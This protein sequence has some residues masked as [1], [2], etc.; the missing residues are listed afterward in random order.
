MLVVIVVYIGSVMSRHVAFQFRTPSSLLIVGPSG[1][2]KTVFTVRLLTD[3]LDLFATRP[4]RMHYCY[5]SWQKTFETLKR[6]GVTFSAGVLSE[7]DLD[8]WFPQGGLLVMD[9][10]M[11][12]GNNDKTV[13]DIFTKHSHHRNITVLY[14]CQDMFPPG[15]YAKS[16]SRNAHYIVAFKNPRDQLGMRNVLLQGVSQTVAEGVGR[17]SSRHVPPVWLPRV[18]SPPG[19]RRRQAPR[20]QR[21]KRGGIRAHLSVGVNMQTRLQRRFLIFRSLCE[22]VLERYETEEWYDIDAM[23]RVLLCDTFRNVWHD[24]LVPY[25]ETYFR[26]QIQTLWGTARHLARGHQLSTS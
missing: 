19:Q 9:D 2:G 21:P 26:E 8:R 5:G 18:G 6:K 14:L 1:S 23:R 24:V 16:I 4:K 11:T 7:K 22:E 20:Q 10:L 12:E 15:K 25:N 17:V 3:N 13:L